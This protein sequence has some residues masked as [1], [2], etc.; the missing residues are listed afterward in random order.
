MYFY[1]EDTK[2]IST[3]LFGSTL[4]KI[5]QM[6]NA[7]WGDAFN[8]T[9]QC[10]KVQLFYYSPWIAGF[11]GIVSLAK[12]GPYRG[13]SGAGGYGSHGRRYRFGWTQVG[14]VI[15]ILLAI[16]SILYTYFKH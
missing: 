8:I 5:I 4:E 2:N 14:I 11:I 6:C 12:A 16:V 3:G 15:A 7:G 1:I 9:S 13:Y 10:I